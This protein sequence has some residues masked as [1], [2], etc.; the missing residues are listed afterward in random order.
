MDLKESQE[1]RRIL[2]RLFG[3]TL[4]KLIW[5][6]VRYGLSAGRVQSPALRILMEKERE[7]RKFIPQK[8]WELH[9]MFKRENGEEYFAEL[10]KI[11]D[12]EKE[13]N[14]I[15][16]NRKKDWKVSEIKKTDQKRSPKPPFTTSTMQQAANSFLSYSPS[17]TMRMAQ[18]LYEA[19][20][21]TYIRTDSVNVSNLALNQAKEH[22]E[23]EYGKEYY[24]KTI[25][26]TKSKAAQEAHEAIRPTDLNFKMVGKTKEEQ[27]LYELIYERFVSSQ[28][29]DAELKRTTVNFSNGE[30]VFIIKGVRITKDGWLK[31]SKYSINKEIILPEFKKDEP[32]ECLEINKKEKETT[33]PPRY[34]EAGLVKELENRGIGRPSTYAS[35]IKTL[36]DREYVEKESRSLKP[37]ELGDVVSSFVEN[38]FM[39]YVNDQFTSKMEEDLDKI[40]EGKLKYKKIL[41]DFFY[42]FKDE[43]DSKGDIKKLTTL[44]DVEGFKCPKCQSEMVYKLSRSGV[45]MSCSK[46]PE[47]TG[48]RTKEGEEIEEPKS[49]GKDCPKCKKG[50]LVKRMGRF[51]AFVSCS[52]YP[53][54]KYI[55]EDEEERKKKD[56]GIKCMKCDNGSMVERRGRFGLFYSCSN[57]PD[58][59]YAIKA[60]P[61][62]KKCTECGSLMMEGTKTIPERCSDKACLMH[63]P[64]KLEKS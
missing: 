57:Y 27:K 63:N 30:D 17:N 39:K 28:M 38:N 22:I 14:Q 2:D 26:K 29:I 3:Y 46:F 45:F 12:T 56:T 36:L 61:T 53:K 8:Y 48:A 1:A 52:N 24:K 35:T 64:H 58:C 20:R 37:T 11:V 18:K 42:P 9:G 21:I 5:Q 47:C 49:I 54:C 43:V 19:G 40:A 32:V 44:G 6:K 41:T 50:E 16:D 55:E 31:A 4:S 62:G 60:K 23:K 10:N 13:A 25:Y 51:G 59:K 33:P 15:V 7:I 34:S